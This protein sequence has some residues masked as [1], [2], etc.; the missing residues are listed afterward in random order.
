M[1]SALS[2]PVETPP[3]KIASPSPQPKKKKSKKEKLPVIAPIPAAKEKKTYE[4]GVRI[5]PLVIN[6]P[7]KD[8][9]TL[10]KK[11]GKKK[12]DSKPVH[13]GKRGNYILIMSRIQWFGFCMFIPLD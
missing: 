11:A 6:E 1:S 13:T 7:F 10:E 2:P 9:H 5:E 3:P 8:S 12:N 4:L